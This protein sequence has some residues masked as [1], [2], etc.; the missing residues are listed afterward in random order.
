MRQVLLGFLYFYPTWVYGQLD[1]GGFTAE[2]EA[3][4]TARVK[5]LDEF[6]NRFNYERDIYNQPILS[7]DSLVQK[8]R[9]YLLHLFDRNYLLEN[10]YDSNFEQQ[11]QE[12][13]DVVTD[14]AKPVLL[15]F[16][17][18]KWYA[19][20]EAIIRYRGKDYTAQVT[21]QTEID[22]AKNSKWVLKGF[23]AD[24]LKIDPVDTTGYCALSPVSHELNFSKLA[25]VTETDSKNILR[26]S[27]ADYSVDYLSIALFLIQTGQLKIQYLRKVCYYFLEVPYYIFEVTH[28]ERD[29]DNSGWL[30]SRLYRLSEPEKTHFIHQKLYIK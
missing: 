26:Y 29:T 10:E 4:L 3:K 28:F 7:D 27:Q 13:L 9:T 17:D 19:Q 20:A 1:L 11:V 23:A 8:R 21:L 25:K 24:I 12:F 15:D 30:I 6:M 18:Y 14:T 22:S 2:Q 16:H 5:Q